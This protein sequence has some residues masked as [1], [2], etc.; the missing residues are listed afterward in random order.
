MT[1]DEWAHLW[2]EPEKY[3][4]VR[5]GEDITIIDRATKHAIIMEDDATYAAVINKMIEAGVEIANRWP[6]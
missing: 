3:I 5:I 2:E 1:Y 4:L 6:F